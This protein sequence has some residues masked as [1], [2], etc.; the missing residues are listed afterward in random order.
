[1]RREVEPGDEVIVRPDGRETD[2]PIYARVVSL[3]FGT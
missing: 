2:I 1:V 3:P